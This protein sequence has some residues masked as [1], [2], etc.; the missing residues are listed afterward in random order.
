MFTPDAKAPPPLAIAVVD[1]YATRRAGAAGVGTNA[2]RP[3]DS[4]PQAHV[5]DVVDM[6]N[7]TAPEDVSEGHSLDA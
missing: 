2:V 6:V 5:I 4:S 3:R 7:I 1:M